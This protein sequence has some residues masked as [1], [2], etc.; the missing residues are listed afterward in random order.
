MAQQIHSS[1]SRPRDRNTNIITQYPKAI[2]T[3]LLLATILLYSNVITSS[4]SSQ[5]N[6]SSQETAS[7]QV[8]TASSEQLS[9]RTP[10]PSLVLKTSRKTA[11]ANIIKKTMGYTKTVI[12]EG[13]GEKPAKGQYVTVHCTGYGK[14]RDMSQKFWSTKDPGQQPFT[15]RIGKQST[16][17]FGVHSSSWF[18]YRC[19]DGMTLCLKKDCVFFF[20][21]PRDGRGYQGLG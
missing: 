19:W 3:L 9:L 6:F 13:N 21:T 4:R 17:F 15:F 7:F 1:L 14:N 11:A 20:L 10:P 12:K 18:Y 8:T 16:L 2:A 5:Q